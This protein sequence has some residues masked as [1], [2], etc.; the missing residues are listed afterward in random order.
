VRA[1]LNV[2]LFI[3]YDATVA[4]YTVHCEIWQ[5]L[6]LV[7]HL[8]HCRGI[9]HNLLLLLEGEGVLLLN[10]RYLFRTIVT[11]V[12]HYMVYSKNYCALLLHAVLYSGGAFTN[13]MLLNALTTEY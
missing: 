7:G 2:Q 11:Q 4:C 6:H 3:C 12:A 1:Y 13:S 10:L 8:Y 5:Q 9:Y